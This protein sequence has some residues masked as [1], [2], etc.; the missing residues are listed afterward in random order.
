MIR[1]N[2]HDMNRIARRAMTKKI[3][4]ISPDV[5]FAVLY[6]HYLGLTGG[7]HLKH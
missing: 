3:R 7:Y 4:L 2:M 6:T 1:H 5:R